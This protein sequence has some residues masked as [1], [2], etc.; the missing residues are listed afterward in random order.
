MVK[1]DKRRLL[2][3]GL[4]LTAFSGAALADSLDAQRQRYQQIKQAWDGNQMDVVAQLMPTLRDYPLYPYLEYRELTQ[5]L[6]QA[7]FSE[8]NDFIKRNPTLPP[9]KSLAPRFVNELARREDWRT[10]LAF[11]PQPPKPVAA[12]CNYYY[13]KWATGDQQ[14]AWSG[15]DELWLNG[16]TLPGACDRLFSV[17]RGAGKQTPLDILARMKLAL[18][19]GNSSLVSNLYS[20]LPP[21]IRPW[22]TPWCACKTI[23]PSWK[24][25]P[26]AWGRPTL[27][28]P[29]PASPLNAWRGRMWKTRGR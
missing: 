2:A 4:C 9:A 29:P 17:W 27:P 11:S 21:I 8:V 1:V 18:K 25:S 7:G 5:D 15:A 20:Q 16:K 23:R 28:A 6:S 24:P 13:A 10:L 22:A 12:R 3:M 26:A 19:E 14:A